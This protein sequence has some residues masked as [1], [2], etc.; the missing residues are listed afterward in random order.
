RVRVDS[1]AP[2]EHQVFAQLGRLFDEVREVAVRI[3]AGG[4]TE[5]T[6]ALG[7][8]PPE[9]EQV[10][11]AGTIEVARGWTG[12]DEAPPSCVT[13]SITAWN[14]H[15]TVDVEG[16]D[17]EGRW[18]AGDVRPGPHGFRLDAWT[19]IQSVHVGPQG[20][21]DARLS[22][23]PPCDV[24]LLL[25]DEGTGEPFPGEEAI[26][27]CSR[28]A[29]VGED[30]LDR[31]YAEDHGNPAHP[32]KPGVYRFRAPRGVLRA[33][34]WGGDPAESARH[35]GLDIELKPGLNRVELKVGWELR[36]DVLLKDGAMPV[37]ADDGFAGGV[38]VEPLRGV[39]A[40][41]EKYAH[42]LGLRMW[43]TKPGRYRVSFPEIE[44]YE[45]IDPVEVDVAPG[46]IPKVEIALR[47][48]ER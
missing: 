46:A 47:R 13:P 30:L 20:E 39:G 11:L 10:P 1:L 12:E 9:P 24:E 33:R 36:I 28:A 37:P 32:E 45:P 15:G 14:L 23:P 19:W 41:E 3:E 6:L 25:V 38:E 8:L 40:E 43:V 29:D 5:A 4:T 16:P 26:S 21:T 48:R 27:W 2:G 17:E 42:R 34:Y 18:S 7:E 44:G 22:V 35:G 31:W